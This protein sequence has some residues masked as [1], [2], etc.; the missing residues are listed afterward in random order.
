MNLAINK[1]NSKRLFTYV[2]HKQN[3]NFGI[4]ALVKGGKITYDKKEISDIINKK[5]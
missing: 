5:F 2:S 1:K 3:L 4:E